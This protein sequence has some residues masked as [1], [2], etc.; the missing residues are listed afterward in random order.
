MTRGI[1]EIFDDCLKNCETFKKI[2][3]QIVFGSP[4]YKYS[5]SD[6]VVAFCE[7][8]D[9]EEVLEKY[10][11]NEDAIN[12]HHEMWEEVHKEHVLTCSLPCCQELR[13]YRKENGV[14]GYE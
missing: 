13:E 2:D 9:L 8:N 11:I 10:C 1:T 6:D 5:V 12:R 14:P 4:K 3:W 7:D